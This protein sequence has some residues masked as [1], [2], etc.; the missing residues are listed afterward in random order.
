MSA[1]ISCACAWHKAKARL[2]GTVIIGI[3]E[4]AHRNELPAKKR[5]IELLSPC[6]VLRDMKLTHQAL[7]SAPSH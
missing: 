5:G 7:I 4:I 3:R 2:A 1:E 6:G